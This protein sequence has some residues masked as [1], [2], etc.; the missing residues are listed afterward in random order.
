MCTMNPAMAPPATPSAVVP[1]ADELAT[2][3]Y[4]RPANVAIR[5]TAVR[6]R[7]LVRIALMAVSLLIGGLGS[8]KGH[9][10]TDL[11]HVGSGTCQA[12]IA[13][14]R[15]ADGWRMAAGSRA[16]WYTADRPTS[17]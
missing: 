4:G 7:V 13:C 12:V 3:Y 14:E 15:P 8:V 10:L 2:C 9:P 16:A 1:L 6:P 5:A 17:P 11:G